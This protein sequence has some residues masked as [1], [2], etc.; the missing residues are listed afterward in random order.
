M[1]TIQELRAH[2][3]D[4]LEELDGVVAL[5]RTDVGTAPHLFRAGGDLSR[6]V[7]EPRYPLASVVSLLQTPLCHHRLTIPWHMGRRW[8]PFMR[9]R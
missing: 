5:R 6:L 1:S 4:K 9:R 2:V 3:A 7:L 8:S